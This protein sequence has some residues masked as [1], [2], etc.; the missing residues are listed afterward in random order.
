VPERIETMS[1]AE[2][3]NPVVV[4]SGSGAI[5]ETY[6]LLGELGASRAMIVSGQN[7]G[8]LPVVRDLATS[9]PSGL[10]IEAFDRVEPDPSDVTCEVGGTA[11]RDFGAQA[12]IGIGGGS[13]MDAAKAIAAEAVTR[14]WTKAQAHPG[15]PTQIDFDPLPVILAPTTAGT[16]SEVTPFSVVTYA[17]GKRKLVLSHPK[18]YARYALLDPEMLLTCSERVR[19]A[20]GMDA[21]THAVESCVSKQGTDRTRRRALQAIALIV[22]HLPRVVADENDIEAQRQLQLGAMIAGLAFS[23]SRLGIVH[24]MALPLSALFQVPH[25]VANAILLSYGMRFNVMSDIAGFAAIAAA[26]GVDTSEM[27]PEQAAMAAVDAVEDISRIVGAPR[28]MSEV[29]VTKDA[30]AQMAEDAMPSA[31][32]ACNPRHIEEQ[33]LIELYNLAF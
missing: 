4:L 28:H 19:V 12:I 30:I 10:E 33:D 11:A 18:L 26:M 8:V 15:E 25:G 7:V 1:F 24:A 9:T 2:D 14:G 31:H 6:R 17:D 3:D 21:L 23:H 13:S 5:A 27:P 20:A 29:G 32:I 22:P 16:A